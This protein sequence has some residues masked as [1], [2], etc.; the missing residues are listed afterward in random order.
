MVCVNIKN[1]RMMNVLPAGS[2]R[3]APAVHFAPFRSTQD[4]LTSAAETVILR[5]AERAAAPGT[6]RNGTHVMEEMA[7]QQIELPA[8][9]EAAL[10]LAEKTNS[11]LET[12][13]NAG[14]APEGERLSG[15]RF[16]GLNKGFGAGLIGR[17]KF[18]KQMFFTGTGQVK[19]LAGNNIVVRQNG[20]RNPYVISLANGIPRTEG[21]YI[22]EA[23]AAHPRWH[24]YPNAALLDY[25]RGGNPW[26]DPAHLLR[27][28]LVQP[29]AGDADLLLGKAYFQLGPLNIF[30][31]FFVLQRAVE[32]E[33]GAGSAS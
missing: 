14:T 28:Y 16:L 12:L 24:H 13:L 1:A 19:I 23:A 15:W 26:Y 17:R 33:P 18:I 8:L 32:I 31:N 2:G 22:I 7:V 6:I 9:G 10:A 25:G 11:A 4:R 30:S 21:A 20:V 5:N 29:F 27:D 3:E